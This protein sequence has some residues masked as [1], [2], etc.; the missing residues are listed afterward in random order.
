MISRESLYLD[1]KASFIHWIL[2]MA[3]SPIPFSATQWYFPASARWIRAN[4]TFSPKDS[5][6]LPCAEVLYHVMFEFG[7]AAVTLHWRVRFVP[8]TTVWSRGYL[9]SSDGESTERSQFWRSTTTKVNNCYF[10]LIES[11]SKELRINNSVEL[12]SSKLTIETIS[13][14][15]PPICTV[16]VF[17]H[18][19]H[20]IPRKLNHTQTVFS[21]GQQSDE[22]SLLAC[23]IDILSHIKL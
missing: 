5:V 23:V 7:L 22:Y 15:W 16:L 6:V 11:L 13:E 18:H 4:V 21:Q 9:E 1:T 8:S 12:F 17:Q 2:D 20:I 19:D 10:I 14:V 3:A